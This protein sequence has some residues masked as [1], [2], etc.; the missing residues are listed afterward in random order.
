[1]TRFHTDE[2]IELLQNVLPENADALT[3]NGTRGK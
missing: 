3:G 2:Y 1:M